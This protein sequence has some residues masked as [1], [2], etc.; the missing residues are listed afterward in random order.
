MTTAQD[1][2]TSSGI[3]DYRMKENKDI[4]GKE[5]EDI[6]DSDG[7]RVIVNREGKII[8]DDFEEE[9]TGDSEVSGDQEIS[10]GEEPQEK[11]AA[12]PPPPP[13]EEDQSPEDVQA[14]PQLE[15]EATQDEH[16]YVHTF[17]S[18]IEDR[19]PGELEFSEWLHTHPAHESEQ[20]WE[21]LKQMGFGDTHKPNVD[22]HLYASELE[23]KEDEHEDPAD[24]EGQQGFESVEGNPNAL[25][26]PEDYSYLDGWNNK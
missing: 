22:D 1:F 2:S 18:N 25:Q 23:D 16:P 26:E 19:T 12:P 20:E 9:T 24:S 11:G 5:L 17:N 4:L 8:R 13:E 21:G 3:S 7:R 6:A 14:T 15:D 10:S